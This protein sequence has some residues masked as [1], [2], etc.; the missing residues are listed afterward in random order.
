MDD[1]GDHP[2]T[3]FCL[4]ID[5]D[6]NRIGD[7]FSLIMP[8]RTLVSELKKEIKAEMAPRLDYLAAN[9]LILWKLTN[10]LPSDRNARTELYRKIKEIK[11]SDHESDEA[12]KGDVQ[13]LDSVETLS[14]YW[15]K[16]PER[17]HLHIIVQAPSTSLVSLSSL[18]NPN[19]RVGIRIGTVGM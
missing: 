6:R 9:E 11:F 5:N 10:S 16:P 18:F 19:I 12:L 3:L 8:S 7:I 4:A 13:L 14:D 2:L 17:R 15:S 1:N